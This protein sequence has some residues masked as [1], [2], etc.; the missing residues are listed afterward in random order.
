LAAATID[1]FGLHAGYV[2]AVRIWDSLM[3][4]A[5]AET[6]EDRITQREDTVIRKERITAVIN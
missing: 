5:D 2:F 3:V 6:E 1:Q 4:C